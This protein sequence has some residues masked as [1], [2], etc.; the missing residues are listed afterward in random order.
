MA[1][2]I[3]PKGREG[4]ATAAVDWTGDN[5]KFFCCDTN[6]HAFNSA[7]DFLDD[8]TGAAI[9]FTSGNL[10]GKS[11]ADGTLDAADETLTA[12]TGDQ[13]EAL[14]IYKDTGLG[15]TSRL[16]FFIDNYTGLPFT[17]NNGNII[18]Q[19]PNDANKIATL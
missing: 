14:I 8:I 19:F 18:V 1:T 2:V 10:S 12:V 9:V 7:N 6:D 5:I 17:P 16:L 3:Y 13:F 15:S 11:A 4:F